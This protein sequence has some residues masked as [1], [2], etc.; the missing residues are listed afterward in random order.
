MGHEYG[1]FTQFNKPSAETE[2]RPTKG[3]TSGCFIYKQR[4]EHISSLNAGC[5]SFTCVTR[6]LSGVKLKRWQSRAQRNARD[7][8]EV[9]VILIYR[10]ENVFTLSTMM[11]YSTKPVFGF[12][13][14]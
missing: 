11:A 1:K 5:M 13:L 14:T 4:N 8:L 12:V 6:S 2:T 10:P 9:L 7:T 3:T